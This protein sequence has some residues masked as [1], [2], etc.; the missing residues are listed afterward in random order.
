M[1]KEL[2]EL[3]THGYER[4]QEVY[5]DIKRYENLVN[6]GHCMGITNT[7]VFLDI[8]QIEQMDGTKAGSSNQASASVET[9]P[10]VM[11]RP[12]TYSISPQQRETT[13]KEN[14]PMEKAV[15]KSATLNPREENRL[16]NQFL[17]ANGK[18]FIL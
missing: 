11:A 7:S 1:P 18:C 14:R 10:D 16:I 15:E 3:I 8:L 9:T 5:E 2:D 6:L 4:L 17:R 12:N 13:G